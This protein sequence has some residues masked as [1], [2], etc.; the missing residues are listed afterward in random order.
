MKNLI[1]IIFLILCVSLI[2]SS[3]M[4]A[5]EIENK[6]KKETLNS[7]TVEQK[8]IIKDQRDQIKQKRELFK[9]SLTEEQK[10]IL[11]NK[12]LSKQERQGALMLS[13][14]K[15][16]MLLLQNHRESVKQNKLYFKNT[17]TKQQRYQIRSKLQDHRNLNDG[18][19]LRETVRETRKHRKKG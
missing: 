19:E 17:I 15:N 13:L 18:N 5:Q 9:A 3:S 7:L 2:T 10:K 12:N 8:K 6:V 1:K 14:N 11:N 4:N 16:Q